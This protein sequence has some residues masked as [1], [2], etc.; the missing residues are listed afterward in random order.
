[1]VVVLAGWLLFGFSARAQ[2]HHDIALTAVR[3][4]TAVQTL[5]ATESDVPAAGPMPSGLDA[6]ILSD[7]ATAD[8]LL[9]H[10]SVDGVVVRRVVPAFHVYRDA[11]GVEL[12][13][14]QK[15]QLKAADRLDDAR[16]DPAFAA[17]KTELARASAPTRAP[18]QRPR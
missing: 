5:D 6:E 15:G 10:L 16:V 13:M 11:L 4:E 9:A 1:M 7:V 2:S 14:L 12:V 3:L 8:G 17:L 18:R